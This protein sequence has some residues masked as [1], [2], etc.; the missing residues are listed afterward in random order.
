VKYFHTRLIRDIAIVSEWTDASNNNNLCSAAVA[1]RAL[2]VDGPWDLSYQCPYI[3][4]SWRETFCQSS[5]RLVAQPWPSLMTAVAQCYS[6]TTPSRQGRGHARCRVVVTELVPS[7]T[8]W[9]SSSRSKPWAGLTNAKLSAGWPRPASPA[10]AV[11]LEQVLPMPSS[12]LDD[13][14]LPV[15]QLQ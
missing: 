13:H 14:G 1:A 3:W 5:G 11:N 4:V 2:T 6:I 12:V 8:E 15:Q 7:S 10:A 9:R